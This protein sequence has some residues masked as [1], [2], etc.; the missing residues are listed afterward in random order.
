MLVYMIS[1][2]QHSRHFTNTCTPSLYVFAAGYF[3]INSDT[4]TLGVDCWPPVMWGF[5]LPKYMY[6]QTVFFHFQHW[7]LS[8]D[9]LKSAKQWM[10][11]RGPSFKEYIYIGMDAIIFNRHG[12]YAGHLIPHSWTGS[13]IILKKREKCGYTTCLMYM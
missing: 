6:I 2:S 4:F 13:S 1:R 8:S 3:P 7:N 12:I 9:D 11:T 5:F 10:E